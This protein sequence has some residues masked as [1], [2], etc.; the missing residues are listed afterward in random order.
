MFEIKIIVHTI[1]ALIIMLPQVANIPERIF[2]L[3]YCAHTQRVSLFL[4]QVLEYIK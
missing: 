2:V 1:S 3:Y 4:L